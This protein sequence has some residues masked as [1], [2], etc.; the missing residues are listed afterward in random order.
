VKLSPKILGPLFV[1]LALVCCG[2]GLWTGCGAVETIESTIF[3]LI[4]VFIL[5]LLPITWL[6]SRRPWLRNLRLHRPPPFSD[7]Q[8]GQLRFSFGIDT[9]LW[10][11]SIALLPGK[12]IPLAVAGNADGPDSTALDLAKDLLLQLP[13]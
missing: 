13:S 1:V 2:I 11:G 12:S 6:C 5:I 7:P 4:A 9:C 10:R 8:L 3:V